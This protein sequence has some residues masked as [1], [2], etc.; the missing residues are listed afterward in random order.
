MVAVQKYPAV[1]GMQKIKQTKG[2]LATALDKPL[3]MKFQT[4]MIEK[5]DYIFKK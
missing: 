5:R 4:A 2:L 1:L 3:H